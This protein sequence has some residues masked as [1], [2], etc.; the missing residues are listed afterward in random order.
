MRRRSVRRRQRAARHLQHW[1]SATALLVAAA[2]IGPTAA[3]GESIT[4][5]CPDGSVF[6]VQ[7]AAAIPCRQAKRV[8]PSDVPPVRPEYL[9][10]PYTWQVYNER[11]DPNN[12]YN[13]IEAAEEVRALGGSGDAGAGR[14]GAP[15][16]EPRE[17]RP[18]V[19]PA[20]SSA[21]AVQP[22]A[23]GLSDDELRDL[24]AIVQLSQETRPA[25]LTRE[26]AAGRGLFAVRFARSRSFERRLRDAW[27]SR[28]G[29]EAGGIL[30]FTAHAQRAEDF[31]P[32]FTV[33][34]EHYSFQPDL[35]NSAQFGLL[36]GRIGAIESDDL[37]L[38]FVVL[39][40]TMTFEGE[41]DIYWDDRRV[42]VNF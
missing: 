20:G 26:S 1:A 23:L 42:S 16:G 33:V 19:A 31:H 17:A 2:G 14:V 7:S 38:G 35:S 22:L 40:R 3:R 34:Q 28:G 4:G 5:V 18:A 6:I 41:L 30:L 11:Q 8:A 37:V 10:S 29:L 12:P 25:E 39:P 24:Y 21:E 9:P 13:L 15:A 36:A 27:E 32:N